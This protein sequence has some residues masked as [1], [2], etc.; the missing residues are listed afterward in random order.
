[1][2]PLP[3]TAFTLATALGRGHVAHADA[4]R[5]GVTGLRAQAFETASLDAWL[6]VVDGVDEQTPACGAGAL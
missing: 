3:I 4:L 6:G 5:N 2:K 1:V